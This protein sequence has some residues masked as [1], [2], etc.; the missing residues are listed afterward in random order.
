ELL[1]AKPRHK[2]TGSRPD[3]RVGRVQ[4]LMQVGKGGLSRFEQALFDEGGKPLLL[5]EQPD[6][7]FQFRLGETPHRETLLAPML[8]HR[9]R[10]TAKPCGCCGSPLAGGFLLPAVKMRRSLLRSRRFIASYVA[11]YVA[12]YGQG[13][14]L[15]S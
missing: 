14:P 12:G 6:Q 11:W 10:S 2:L 3:E 15:T 8:V 7:R 1:K 13:L 5:I 4:S 9:R